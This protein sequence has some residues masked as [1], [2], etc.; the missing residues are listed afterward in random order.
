MCV[1]LFPFRINATPPGAG[2]GNWQRCEAVLA[3]WGTGKG[4]PQDSLSDRAGTFHTDLLEGLGNSFPNISP[5][6]R[7]P[8]QPSLGALPRPPAPRAGEEGC[9]GSSD[10]RS[11]PTPSPIPELG[12]SPSPAS[13]RG[14]CC[15]R[16]TR[17]GSAAPCPVAGRA[18]W[19]RSQGYKQGSVW[20]P[21]SGITGCC[22]PCV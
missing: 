18:V 5:S 4:S 14:S 1:I 8:P 11:T 17:V 12:G 7:L 9:S 6:A 10:R 22:C 20:D 21:L 19:G 13:V 16:K 2:H 3:V 15:S